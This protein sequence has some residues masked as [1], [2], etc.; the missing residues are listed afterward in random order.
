MDYDSA[1]KKLLKIEGSPTNYAWDSGGRTVFGI[2][3][4]YWPQYWKN[5]PPTFDVAKKFYKAEFWKP[6]KLD[7][8]KSG[9]LRFEMFEAGVNCGIG[10]AVRFAQNAY[11]LLKQEDWPELE[12]DGVIG[13]N[14]IRALNKMATCYEESLLAGCNFFQADYYVSLNTKL[15]GKA[16]RGWFAKRLCWSLK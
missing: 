5:G 7:S 15:K 10:N 12:V 6:M 4:V 2:A 8:I 1:L 9:N 13:P 11:N 16:L 3:E 14:T